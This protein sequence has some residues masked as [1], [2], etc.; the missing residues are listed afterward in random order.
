MNADT[1]PGHRPSIPFLRALGYPRAKSAHLALRP[2]C[3]VRT[4][5]GISRTEESQA[6][7]RGRGSVVQLRNCMNKP[8][9]STKLVIQLN[10]SLSPIPRSSRMG[11]K[12]FVSQL[13]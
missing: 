5:C 3:A 13:H 11:E 12:D 6:N 8:N 4:F 7:R 2:P 9:A 10:P 1:L